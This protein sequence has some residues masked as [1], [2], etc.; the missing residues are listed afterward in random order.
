M[1]QKNPGATGKRKKIGGKTILGKN[2]SAL[3]GFL[4][5][6]KREDKGISSLLRKFQL[7]VRGEGDP[8]GKKEKSGKECFFHPQVQQ[9]DPKDRKKGIGTRM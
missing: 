8:L 5:K 4:G 6:D 7:G 9:A 1:D 2:E 3:L